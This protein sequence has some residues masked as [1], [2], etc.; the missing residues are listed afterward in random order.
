MGKA[1]KV[2]VYNP[3]DEWNFIELPHHYTN[4][5]HGGPYDAP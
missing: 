3:K 5:R 2:P 1:E 4:N